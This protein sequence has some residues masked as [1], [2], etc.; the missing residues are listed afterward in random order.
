MSTR[1]IRDQMTGYWFS[2]VLTDFGL[3]AFVFALASIISIRVYPNEHW[4]A[5]P[6]TRRS[7]YQA[8]M[9]VSGTLLGLTLTSISIL[10]NSLKDILNAHPKAR[11]HKSHAE[12]G[13]K[14]F[15][16]AVRALGL[17]VLVFLFALATVPSVG[18]WNRF[19]PP[20]A[21]ATL[22]LIT[23]RLGRMLWALCLLIQGTTQSLRPIPV[24]ISAD[25]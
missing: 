25:E 5:A 4:L 7:I 18:A 6:E 3:S 10:N 8:C 1:T 11:L 17:A 23:L 9:T 24:P 14:I 12:N 16:A 22:V 20:L 2:V 21:L 15:F 19:V 13:T